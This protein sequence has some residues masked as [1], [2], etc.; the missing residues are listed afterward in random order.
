MD[1]DYEDDKAWEGDVGD[2]EVRKK[3]LDT[4]CIHKYWYVIIL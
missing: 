2:I 4:V 1:D 3:H